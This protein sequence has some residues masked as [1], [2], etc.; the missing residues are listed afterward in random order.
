MVIR[1]ILS[2]IPEGVKSDLRLMENYNTVLPEDSGFMLTK[3]NKKKQNKK[4]QIQK[5]NINCA[6]ISCS[7]WE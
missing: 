2:D 7:L 3:Q 6:K 5:R 4:K 1:V